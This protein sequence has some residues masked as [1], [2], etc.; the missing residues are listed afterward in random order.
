MAS[1][2]PDVSPSNDPLKDEDGYDEVL[3]LEPQDKK[4]N[5]KNPKSRW[6]TV[7]IMSNTSHILMLLFTV[8]VLILSFGDYSFFSWHPALMTLGSLLFMGEAVLAISTGNWLT[9]RLNRRN[10]VTAHWVLQAIAAAC[11]FAGFLIIFINKNRKGKLH[12]QSLHGI[13]GLVSVI[14]VGITSSGGVA[15]LYTTRLKDIIKPAKVK[16]AHNVFGIITFAIGIAST[17]LGIYSG[18]FTR[19]SNTLMQIV[20]VIV[21]TLASIFAV[22][23]AFKSAYSRFV[24]MVQGH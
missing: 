19:H 24:N 17:I 23:N 13:V 5:T 20:S 8:Y 12:F 9:S 15:A 14:F 1:A 18:W 22:I 3:Q 4:P 10:R 2:F 21:V 11:I 16:F 6:R 7:N